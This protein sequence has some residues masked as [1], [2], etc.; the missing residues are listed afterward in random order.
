MNDGL[1]GKLAEQR[2]THAD[3]ADFGREDLGNVE[4]HGSV[5]ACTL[6]GLAYRKYGTQ[7]GKLRLTLGR[8][9]RGR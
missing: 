5:T 7:C 3:G 1:T 2:E 6:K 9:D 4:I 8:P